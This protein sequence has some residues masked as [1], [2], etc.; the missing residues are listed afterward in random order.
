MQG[1]RG[2][3]DINKRLVDAVGKVE[4]G[5]I[6]ETS[7]ETYTLPYVKWIDSGSLPYDPGNPKPVLYANLEGWDGDRG[8]RG[9]Q[10]GG[11]H[12]IVCKHH[13]NIID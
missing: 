6:R 11:I 12:V 9:V 2:D 8:G 1:S 13:H 4:G 10:E 5:T 7:M 3:T